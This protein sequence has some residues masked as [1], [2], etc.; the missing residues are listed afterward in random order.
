MSRPIF[1]TLAWLLIITTLIILTG[2]ATQAVPIKPK[3]PEAIQSLKA[4][5]SELKEIPP[6]T[7][8]L[9]EAISIIAQNY[10]IYHECKIKVDLW[11]EW[12]T[13]QKKIYD[14]VK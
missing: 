7:T 12:Y 4:P 10:G 2:C 3:F 14:E 6:E 5:C 1:V 9:S 13:E 11:N 8:K